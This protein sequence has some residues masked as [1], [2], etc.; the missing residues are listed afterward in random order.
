M[1]RKNEIDDDDNGNADDSPYVSRIETSYQPM[2]IAFHPHRDNLLA[3]AL[4]DGS[5]EGT[6]SL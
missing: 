3:A 4:V 1:S 2:D 6:F 5:L